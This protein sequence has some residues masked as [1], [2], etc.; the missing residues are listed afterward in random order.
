MSRS[1]GK[2]CD[3]FYNRV[4]RPACTL[5]TIP[6]PSSFSVRI[7]LVQA[8]W[9]TSCNASTRLCPLFFNRSAAIESVPAPLFVFQVFQCPFY[10]LTARQ[11]NVNSI[12]SQIDWDVLVAPIQSFRSSVLQIFFPSRQHL[13]FVG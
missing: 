11:I 1:R 7:L 6:P 10:F 2:S 4:Y 3:S 9:I 12:I 5:D 13:V 8:C